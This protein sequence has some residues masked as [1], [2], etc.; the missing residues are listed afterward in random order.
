[1]ELGIFCMWTE[2]YLFIVF[3]II[4]MMDCGIAFRSAFVFKLVS[5]NSKL[6]W[7]N[8]LVRKNAWKGKKNARKGKMQA[9]DER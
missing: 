6:C 8:A 2:T 1:M 4:D 7:I 9:K 3:K 5:K